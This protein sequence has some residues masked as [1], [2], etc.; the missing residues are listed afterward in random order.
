MPTKRDYARA[1]AKALQAVADHIGA[2]PEAYFGVQ[3]FCLDEGFDL[4]V[5][6]E[7]DH[8]GVAP[9][10]TLKRSTVFADEDEAL[11]FNW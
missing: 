6:L 9:K 8:S 7:R 5:H 10:V 4:Q 1:Y 2:H 11:K 3:D